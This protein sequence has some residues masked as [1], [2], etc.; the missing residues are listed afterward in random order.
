MKTFRAYLEQIEEIGPY[1][2]VH[3]PKVKQ[4]KNYTCGAAALRAIC[5]LYNVGPKSEKQFIKDC[6][7]KERGTKPDDIIRAARSYGLSV[8][9]KSNMSLNELKKYLDL[10]RPVICCIQAYGGKEEYNERERGHY[11]V[12][13]GYDPALIYFEDPY[14]KDSRGFLSCEEFENRWHDEDYTGK[15]YKQFGMVIWKNTGPEK[16]LQQV[17][18]AKKIP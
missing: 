7:T 6:K 15:I 2:K 4:T 9:A 14:M 16:D 13:C 10:G 5:K 1:I 11:V 17:P 18:Q 3:L 12:A 8:K